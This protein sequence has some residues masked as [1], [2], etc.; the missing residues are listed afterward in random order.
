MLA[1]GSPSIPYSPYADNHGLLTPNLG[2]N[3]T[4]EKDCSMFIKDDVD[5]TLTPPAPIYASEKSR[6]STSTQDGV[7]WYV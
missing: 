7:W 3:D 4:L 5:I 6:M 2:Q 1:A